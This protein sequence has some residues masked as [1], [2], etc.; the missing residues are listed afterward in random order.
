MSDSHKVFSSLLKVVRLHE[1][2]DLFI[3]LGDGEN[4]IRQLFTLKPELETK[5]LLLKGNCDGGLLNPQTKL[6][7]D[8][9]LPYG[10]KIFAAHGDHFRVNWGSAHMLEEA[11]KRHADIM[12]YGHT[13][14]R[15]NRYE[16]GVYI[17]NP[18][19]L[20]WPRDGLKQSYGV[21]SISEKGV[22]INIAD[23]PLYG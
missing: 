14:C 9:T 8:Y 12:L 18:G 4:D 19:S 6:E 5:F 13:H 3:F 7:L 22:L 20:G 11:K 17:L 23:V 10:H 21:L 16:D 2:A 15:E 1:D